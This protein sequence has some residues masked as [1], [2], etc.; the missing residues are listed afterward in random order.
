MLQMN[1]ENNFIIGLALAG[2]DIYNK[3]SRDI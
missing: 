3:K 1:D 2:Y